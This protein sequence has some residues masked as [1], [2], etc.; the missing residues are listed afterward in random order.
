MKNIY[1]QDQKKL[2][3]KINIFKKEGFNKLH[4]ISD[5]DGTL[6]KK[7]INNKKI[8]S[9]ISILRED[10]KYLGKDYADRAKEL[11]KFYQKYENNTSI[12]KKEKKKKMEEWWSNHFKLLIE[13]GLNKKHLNSILESNCIILRKNVENFLDFLNNKNIPIIIVSASGL[14]DLI[15]A[16]FQKKKFNHQNINYIINSF[17]YDKNNFAKKYNNNIIHSLNKDETILENFPKIYKKIKNKKNVILL[18]NSLGDTG[19]I[20]GFKFDNLI[21]IGFL[22]KKDE[23]FDKKIKEYINLYDV[24]ITNDDYDFINKEIF[25]LK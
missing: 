12:T 19:M 16:Y 23:E 7:F 17:E 9:I 4:V 3:Q 2:R 20:D 15:P 13:K 11:F 1:F 18:G 14:G 6:S 25:S 5:F 24:V 21:K 22:D 10:N 8:P